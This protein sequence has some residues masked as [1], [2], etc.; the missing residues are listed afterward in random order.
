MDLTTG[1]GHRDHWDFATVGSNFFGEA[2][3]LMP[4]PSSCLSLANCQSVLVVMRDSQQDCDVCRCQLA[5]QG[6]FRRSQSGSCS[7][8]SL[9][10]RRPQEA[11]AICTSIAPLGAKKQGG[12]HFRP[13]D[14]PERRVLHPTT[15]KHPAQPTSEVQPVEHF[16]ER[17][18]STS[19]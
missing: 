6:C 7:H 16:K 5:W 10:T 15:N 11:R 1:Y 9:P 8:S 14:A 3:E 2:Q 4:L 18:D 12:S 19:T 17:H 13:H